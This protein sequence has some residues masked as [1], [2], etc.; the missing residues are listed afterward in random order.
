MTTVVL[1]EKPDQGRKFAKALGASGTSH[2]KGFIE[3]KEDSSLLKDHTIVTWGIGHLVSLVEPDAYDEKY[4]KWVINDLPIIPE[5]MK[6]WINK[7]TRQQFN[8]VK[9]QLKKAD[10][11]IIA[12]DPD[13][14]GENIA[15]SI[16]RMC[17]KEIW[18][19]PKKRL[20]INSLQEK[21]IKRGFQALRDSKETF[22]YFVEAGT[23]QIAD[24]L[25]G[26]NLTRY[27]SLLLQS[28]KIHSP[29]GKPWSIGRVQTPTNALI[30]KN[31]LERLNFK[32]V[33]YYQLIGTSKVNNEGIRFVE[34]KE[35]RKYF[36]KNEVTQLVARY[37]LNAISEVQVESV[38]KELKAKSAPHLFSLGGLQSYC[39]TQFG[40]TA[41]KTLDIAQT[42][43]T[44]GLTSYPRTNSSLITDNEFK[45]LLDNIDK[46][47]DY[48]HTNLTIAH[49]EP[50][51]QYVDSD[52]V[53]EH[54]AIIPTDSFDKIQDLTE[55]EEK[56]YKAIIKQTLAMF[57]EDYQYYKTTVKINANGIPFVTNGNESFKE[58]W[59]VITADISSQKKENSSLPRLGKGQTIP[60]TIEVESKETTPPQ[61]ITEAKLVSETGLMAKLNLGTPA[62][63]ADIIET[64]KSREYIKNDGKTKL[65]PTPRG[66]LL[67]DYTKNLLVGSPEM[68]AKWE[69]YLK[70]IGEG[71]N[72]S[73]TFIGKIKEGIPIIFDKMQQEVKA[74]DPS[75]VKGIYTDKTTCI[76]G[77]QVIEKNKSFEI[78]NNTEKFYIFKTIA[79]GK[80][81][82]SDIKELLT[83]GRTKRKTFVSKKKKKFEAILV[84]QNDKK[85]S[86]CFED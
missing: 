40:Y 31:Y 24:W 63:R 16:F 72:D 34:D 17:G 83:N 62:T 65:V 47:Q 56:V 13:R 81:S 76:N 43:Y 38:E 54:Y 27:F 55:T 78:S 69:I 9:E 36:D 25:I 84:L 41:K 49:R 11:I 19:K 61:Q 8:I 66:L 30:C 42:L 79:G 68:T 2:T 57:L 82:L 26:M 22:N 53:K 67:Y 10:R 75:K 86:F 45:Y 12:T 60:F 48:I 39:S 50:R 37:S 18:G 51:K 59:K 28:Q 35:N 71:K 44:K 77:Y 4:K 73:A 33:P 80:L 64:L 1:A 7:S 23:R 29:K 15:Y 32:P 5:T 70:G 3:I 74:I 85:L 20:W 14:E 58:G 21:E 46:Y 52:K 6:Y